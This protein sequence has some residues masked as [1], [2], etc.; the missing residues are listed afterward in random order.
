MD[1]DV[2]QLNRLAEQQISSID[3]IYI[4][5]KLRIVD[6]RAVLVIEYDK[7]QPFGTPGLNMYKRSEL[8]IALR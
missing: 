7:Y 2:M 8:F 6:Q 3:G 5:W 1:Y 4:G